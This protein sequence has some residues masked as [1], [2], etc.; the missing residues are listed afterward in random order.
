MTETA[1]PRGNALRPL[2]ASNL[3][4]RLVELDGIVRKFVRCPACGAMTQVKRNELVAHNAPGTPRC[5][6]SRRA[7]INDLDEADWASAFTRT[8]EHVVR[9]RASRPQFFKPSP[10]TATPVAHLARPRTAHPAR[11]AGHSPKALAE[12]D[13]QAKAAA[14]E[15]AKT[16]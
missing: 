9:S 8:A 5:S 6:N 12:L 11:T 13:R 2:L 7:L 16:Q 3:T 10:P 4:A 1:V 15:K 14:R